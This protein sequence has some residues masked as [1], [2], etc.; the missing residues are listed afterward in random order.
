MVCRKEGGARTMVT[1]RAWV[2]EGGGFSLEGNSS[3][4]RKMEKSRAGVV[5][6]PDGK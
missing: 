3:Y 6:L 2:R 4:G 1:V 5:R